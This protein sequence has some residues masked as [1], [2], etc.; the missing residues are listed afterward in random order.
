MFNE[1]R[2]AGTNVEIL[3]MLTTI[4]GRVELVIIDILHNKRMDLGY[5]KRLWRR[6]GYNLENTEISFVK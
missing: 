4:P 1:A 2:M 6:T 5:V 3:S